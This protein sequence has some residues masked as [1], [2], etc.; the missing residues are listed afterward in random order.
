MIFIGTN[1]FMISIARHK[2]YTEGAK[3]SVFEYH[4]IKDKIKN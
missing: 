2:N 1:Y 4:R 3:L